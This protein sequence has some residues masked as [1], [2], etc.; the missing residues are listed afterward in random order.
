MGLVID[1]TGLYDARKWNQ[2]SCWL[3]GALAAKSPSK[4]KTFPGQ[5]KPVASDAYLSGARY[6]RR[7]ATQTSVSE[8]IRSAP[9]AAPESPPPPTPR[10][11]SILIALSPAAPQGAPNQVNAERESLTKTF[12]GLVFV[13][14]QT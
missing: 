4:P 11:M 10:P 8:Y 1:I 12:N 14:P 6:V 13:R 3:Q 7:G 5:I 9:T 2:G